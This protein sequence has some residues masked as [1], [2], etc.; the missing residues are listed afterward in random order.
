MPDDQRIIEEVTQTSI[1]LLLKEPFFSHFFSAL[2]KEVVSFLD[3]LGVGL[4]D[5]GHV[6]YINASFWD[7]LLTDKTHRYGVIKHEVLH[8]VLKHT[9]V[10][11]PGLDRHVVNIA[12]DIVV[13][14][15]I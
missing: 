13:N 6:L 7:N 2:N 4:R 12:M 3:T 11:Q 15:Y 14:Q 1:S 5:R 10:N 9:L 8:I